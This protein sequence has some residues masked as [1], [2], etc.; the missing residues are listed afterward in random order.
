MPLVLRYMDRHPELTID[1]GFDDRYVN[2]VEQ[3]VDLAIR[4]GPMA[5]STLGA[6][7]LGINP[8]VMV[9][10]PS[11]LA[12]RGTP[13]WCTAACRATTAGAW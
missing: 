10:A 4:M 5:D 2:L 8:W 7:Y 12:A 13:A 9:A 11:Y 1:L 6:R 3:G